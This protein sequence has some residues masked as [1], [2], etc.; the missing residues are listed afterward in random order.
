MSKGTFSVYTNNMD[1]YKTTREK[2]AAWVS[3][4]YNNS[5]AVDS[6]GNMF[7]VKNY[8]MGR[9]AFVAGLWRIQDIFPYKIVRVRDRDMVLLDKIDWKENTMFEFWNAKTVGYN[10]YGPFISENKIP[11]YIVAKYNTADGV[12]MGYGKTKE[13]ARA[14][15]GLKVYDSYKDVVHLIANRKVKVK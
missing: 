9:L 2:S 12:Y 3:A 10:C 13:E 14:F 11:D 7:P 5:M 15:L 8:D 6:A 1:E 4:V